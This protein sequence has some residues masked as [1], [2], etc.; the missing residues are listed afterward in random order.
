[1]IGKVKNSAIALSVMMLAL[2]VDVFASSDPHKPC[3]E[4]NSGLLAQ[5]IA[6]SKSFCGT[7]YRYGGIN[8]QGIDCSGLMRTA[9]GRH[10]LELPHSSTRLRKMGEHV[11]KSSIQ[12]GDLLFFKGRNINSNST[13]HVALVTSICNGKIEMVHATRRGVVVDILDDEPY[14]LNRFLEARRIIDYRQMESLMS[15]FESG[16]FRLPR[17]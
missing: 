16:M 13:G 3:D 15:L 5:I 12:P 9:F 6:T 7:P 8:N 14:Y 1:M 17:I 11:D 4:F 2:N 10:N